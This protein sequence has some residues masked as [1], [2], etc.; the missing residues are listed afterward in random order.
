[1]RVLGQPLKRKTFP[2]YTA[3]GREKEAFW[4]GIMGGAEGS[5]WVLGADTTTW[6]AGR[7][8]GI[9]GSGWRGGSTMTSALVVGTEWPGG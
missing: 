7:L 6:N 4:R 3:S 8:G 5:G 9:V 1:M 2:D